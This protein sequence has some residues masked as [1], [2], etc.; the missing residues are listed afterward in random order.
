MRAILKKLTVWVSAYILVAA[1]ATSSE[2]A[3]AGRKWSIDLVDHS[4][5]T[6]YTSL[7]VDSHGNVHVA[8]VVED[9][10]YTL[11][12]SF[13]DHDLKRWFTMPIGG[14]ASFCA[15]TLDSKERP[16]ISWADQ[17]TSSGTKLRYA[18]WDGTA[19][20]IRAIP[21]N[22]DVIAYYTS[23]A[24]DREDHPSLSFYEYRGPQGTELVDR[25]R[26]VS[27]TGKYWAVRTVDGENQS[28]K[29]NSLVADSQG[30]LHLAYAN[31]GGMTAGMRYALWD[32]KSWNPEVIEGLHENNGMYVGYGASLAVDEQGNPHLSY[33]NDSNGLVKYAVKKNGL[34]HIEAIDKIAAVA[35]PDRNSVALD[36]EGHPYISYYDAGRGTLKIAHREGQKWVAEVVDGNGV[37]FTSSLQI[38]DG[39][40]WVSYADDTTQ[41]LKVAHAELELPEVN[42]SLN[43]APGREDASKDRQ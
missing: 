42:A 26:V 19:W 10:H 37:G 27:W 29:F 2:G 12:Y 43:P 6:R 33:M 28:G 23:I 15:L 9:G 3:P 34:W 21:L 14:G 40:L 32:G 5:I 18:F 38:R 16:Y 36:R 7:R 17:G 22:S 11:K 20:Q 4:G 30:R 24:L 41:G 25:M 31:V 13:W 35:Y 39:M 1:L 8:Y